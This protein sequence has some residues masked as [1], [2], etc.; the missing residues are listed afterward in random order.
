MRAAEGI[1][2]K[3]ERDLAIWTIRGYRDAIL[4]I[5]ESAY[6]SKD[7]FDK[8]IGDVQSF[9]NRFDSAITE[10]ASAI[11]YRLVSEYGFPSEVFAKWQQDR[12]FSDELMTTMLDVASERLTP[13]ERVQSA[14]DSQYAR[15]MMMRRTVNTFCL[16]IGK[17]EYNPPSGSDASTISGMRV[18][19]SGSYPAALFERS[20]KA[21]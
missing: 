19:V 20:R 12:E 5:L 3:A 13:Y 18:N 11:K 4:D 10:A 16:K 8:F 9:R 2:D 14:L 7:G 6:E 21:T 1:S 15:I 17:I